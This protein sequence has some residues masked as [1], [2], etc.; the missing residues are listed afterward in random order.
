VPLK[1]SE[2]G[3]DAG[4]VIAEHFV[5]KLESLF[6]TGIIFYT[7]KPVN[8]QVRKIID[9][10]TNAALVHGFEKFKGIEPLYKIFRELGLS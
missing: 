10:I 6:E 9:K 3:S 4:L 7:H 8:D 1:F 5:R 2:N